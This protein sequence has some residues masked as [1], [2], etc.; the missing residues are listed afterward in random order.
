[1]QEWNALRRQAPIALWEASV[2]EKGVPRWM[3]SQDDLKLL[4]MK[5]VNRKNVKTGCYTLHPHGGLSFLGRRYTS[6]GLLDRLRGK[7]FDIYFDRRDISV[8][9]LFVDG[10]LVG[11]AYCTEFLH[12]RVSIWEANAERHA[13]TLQ[14][15]AATARSLSNRQ[16]IQQ[17]ATAG[18]RIHSL[19]TRRLEKQRQMDLQRP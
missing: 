2:Q 11:E 4:L 8:I 10:I 19:E 5:A 15:K 14:A 1:M 7:E 17:E 13:D 9:Y 16:C 12:R 3:G 6:P 18:R